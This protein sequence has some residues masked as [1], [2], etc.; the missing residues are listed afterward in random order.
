MNLRYDLNSEGK[1]SIMGY[2]ENLPF[3][4]TD[5]PFG[6][7]DF[8]KWQKINNQWQYIGDL[9]E[10]PENPIVV[11]DMV[12]PCPVDETVS[13]RKIYWIG[14]HHDVMDKFR[15][16]ILVLHF[17]ATGNRITKWDKMTWTQA[18]AQTMIDNPL[19]PGE[20]VNEYGFF[21]NVVESGQ[22]TLS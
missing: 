18:D 4:L 17:D 16:N 5:E 15:I 12:P 14:E 3:E 6:F 7:N 1:V 10:V 22:M 9:Y 21:M 19:N 20:Q 8:A 11:Y 13:S 2:L